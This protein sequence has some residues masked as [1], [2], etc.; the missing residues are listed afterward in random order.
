V[1]NSA[2]AAPPGP[3]AFGGSGGNR[4]TA[5][6]GG[7][8]G[9]GGQGGG[10]GT[11]L[12]GGAVGTGGATRAGGT[13]GTAGTTPSGGSTTG[14]ATGAGDAYPFCNY[15]TVPEGTPP[16]AWQ[17]NPTLTPTNVNPYGKPALTKKLPRYTGRNNIPITVDTG[18]TEVRVDFAPDAAGSKGTPADM[19]AQIVYHATD[20]SSVFSPPVASGATAIALTKAPKNNVVIV[21]I[22]NV[23]MSG[24]VSAQ[25]YGWDPT[26]TFGYK[27][28]VTGG[29][30]APTNKKYF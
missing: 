11:T 26:E 17:E 30:A 24:Y 9:S 16:S 7:S 14:G 18:A 22:A 23:T 13:T 19:R 5:S 3:T 28:Q 1:A 21:V 6:G 27:I 12:S 25:S 8:V 29:T 4:T 20:G 2:R 10:A 15:G